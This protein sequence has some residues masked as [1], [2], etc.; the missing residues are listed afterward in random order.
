MADGKAKLARPL[1]ILNRRE[2]MLF[3][4]EIFQ[5]YSEK[6]QKRKICGEG[7]TEGKHVLT[8]KDNFP[9]KK[10]RKNISKYEKCLAPILTVQFIG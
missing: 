9:E 7:G 10:R 1:P 5:I 6:K 8:L 4:S 3:K 2:N